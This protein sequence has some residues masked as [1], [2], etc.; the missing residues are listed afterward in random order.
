VKIRLSYGKSG[1]EITVP[2]DLN[3]DI[4]ESQNM[5]G[6]LDQATAVREALC[7]PIVC[8]SLREIAKESDRICIVVNDI[9]RDTIRYHPSGFTR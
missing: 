2:D 7:N 5:P 3:I 6:L 8:E 4:M 1:L 9:T